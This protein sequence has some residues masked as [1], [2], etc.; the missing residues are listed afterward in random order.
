M[1]SAIRR[2]RAA[3]VASIVAAALTA[4]A[5]GAASAEPTSEA[6]YTMVAFSDGNPNQMDVYE[7]TD[8]TEF[9]V[10]KEAAYRPPSGRVRDPSIFR[11]TDGNYYVTYTTGDGATIGFAR[12]PDRVTWTHLR[13]HPVPFCCALLP[14]TG[15][16]KGPVN[17]FGINGSAG[18]RDGPSLSPFTTKAWAP[19][20][21]VDGGKVH[22]ILSMST[23]GGFVPYVMT[24]QNPAL[25]SWSWPVPFGGLN[26][27]RIDTTVVKVGAKYHAIVKNEHKKVL[28]HAV[29]DR[30]TGPFAPRELAS[31]GT[32]VEGPSVVQLPNGHWR[33]Y[34]DSYR[35]KKYY[36]ADSADGMK[37]W[38]P[39]RELPGLSG[40]V[41]HFT[42]LREQA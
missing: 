6:R 3:A 2:H 25:T 17:P 40:T 11:H 35:E 5:T 1:S 39:R 28:E 27:D 21:F 37:T 18:F 15:D 8:G 14:G 12:S 7:S 4:P 33:L 38:S 22:V 16:G 41:R 26:A 30:P 32:L 23:G 29:A 13:N 31:L 20:W 9:R 36:Y 24:A 19:E 10:L 34:F 42:V